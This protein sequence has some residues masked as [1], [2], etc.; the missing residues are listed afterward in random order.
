MDDNNWFKVYY[1]VVS[2]NWN[3]LF[4]INWFL[5]FLIYH[6]R[7]SIR[8]LV[9]IG[10]KGWMRLSPNVCTTTKQMEVIV[11]IMPTWKFIETITIQQVKM[12]T[13]WKKRYALF[14]LVITTISS[15]QG[16]TSASPI[17]KINHFSWFSTN[18]QKILFKSNRSSTVINHI[19]ILVGD[20]MTYCLPPIFHPSN[21]VDFKPK[22]WRHSRK[23][24][25]QQVRWRKRHPKNSNMTPVGIWS[26]TDVTLRLWFWK[27][28]ELL[29]SNQRFCTMMKKM[30]FVDIT[31][32]W[33][34]NQ[35]MQTIASSCL[36]WELPTSCPIIVE[37]SVLIQH[38]NNAGN[39]KS[40]YYSYPHS[41]ISDNT[42][43]CNV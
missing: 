43:M 11:L 1:K 35:K 25:Q 4:L 23:H 6:H 17:R 42:N 18:L 33:L 8:F 36:P 16:F 29:N 27:Q 28:L 30:K 14:L 12:V 10:V 37:A 26:I 19:K 7:R 21:C 39:E 3:D 9:T 38:R 5:T 13:K 31:A 24:S 40:W 34:L 15:G 32:N 41:R 22:K 20:E 2:K